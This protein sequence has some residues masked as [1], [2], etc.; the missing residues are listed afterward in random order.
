MYI[1]A[2]AALAKGISDG[3]NLNI[4][5]CSVLSSRSYCKLSTRLH[6]MTVVPHLSCSLFSGVRSCSENDK[7][8]VNSHILE[9]ILQSQDFPQDQGVLELLGRL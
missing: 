6:N 4:I 3:C 8:L 5:K 2:I 9:T 1:N 7:L